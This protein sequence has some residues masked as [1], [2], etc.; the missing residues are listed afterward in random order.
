MMRTKLGHG[1]SDSEASG[2]RQPFRSLQVRNSFI[3]S[4]FCAKIHLQPR[5]STMIFRED[6]GPD[7]FIGGSFLE[8]KVGGRLYHM[9]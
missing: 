8:M 7:P 1:Q 4:S 2:I 5:R 9:R 3:T 6:L